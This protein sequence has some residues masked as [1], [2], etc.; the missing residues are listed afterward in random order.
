MWHY[1]GSTKFSSRGAPKS[2]SSIA[3]GRRAEQVCSGLGAVPEKYNESEFIIAAQKRLTV[4][5][6][7]V[8]PPLSLS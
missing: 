3:L 5:R 1:V 8:H 4:L 6:I 7:R 2:E